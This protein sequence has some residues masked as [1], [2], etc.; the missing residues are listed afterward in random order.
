MTKVVYE[1]ELEYLFASVELL[2]PRNK[3]S[4]LKEVFDETFIREKERKFPILFEFYQ[5]V[6]TEVAFQIL[7]FIMEYGIENFS[8][9]GYF[10]FLRKKSKT[11]F[12]SKFLRETEENVECI[13]S[14]E[15]ECIYF[16]QRN[17]DIFKN[18]LVV[19]LIVR[20]TEIFLETYYDFVESL[21]I[22]SIEQYLYNN[23]EMLNEWKNKIDKELENKEPLIFS[24]EIMG[25]K[26]HNRG[27]YKAFYFMPSLFL[28][29]KCCRWFEESQFLVVNIFRQSNEIQEE[30]LLE[31]LKTLSDRTRYR[32]LLL[33]QKNEKKSGVEIAANLRLATSTVSHHMAE[34][35]ECGLV[36]EERDG[37]AKYY[38]IN[39]RTMRNC[40]EA[41]EKAFLH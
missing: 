26:F 2:S 7:D 31:Q 14:S 24:E 16:Y 30:I 13:I 20:R 33:L 25:K 5:S 18:Y 6:C 9:K 3:D 32:I 8:V 12:L 10:D 34:L 1:R 11:E 40:I 38:S 29:M 28:P 21:K 36:N 27:P 39:T 4:K 37:N 35:K 19:D 15:S 22:Q 23:N 41:L 17:K